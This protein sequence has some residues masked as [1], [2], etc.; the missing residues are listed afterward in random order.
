MIF[1]RNYRSLQNIMV[2]ELIEPKRVLM[3]IVVDA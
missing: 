3:T 1:D 2:L